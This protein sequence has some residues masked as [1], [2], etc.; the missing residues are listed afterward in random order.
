MA[1]RDQSL[2]AQLAACAPQAAPAPPFA[3]VFSAHGG[4]VISL[5]RRLGVAEADLDD[6]AQDVFIT[7]HAKLPAFEGRSALKTWLCG[8][9]LR[10]AAS[11]RRKARTRRERTT[12]DLP[13]LAA[14]DDPHGELAHKQSAALLHAALARLPDKQR[15]VFVLYEIEELEMADV[16]RALGCPRFTAYTRLHAAR[17]AVR[18][19]FSRHVRSER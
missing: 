9:C 15:E 14:C 3:A 2:A 13:E 11:Y 1:E 16:A 6:V 7:V 12:A 5:L 19:F 4:Y 18:A 10:K 17:S 8:I